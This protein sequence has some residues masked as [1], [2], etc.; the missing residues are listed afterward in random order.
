MDLTNRNITNNTYKDY[1]NGTNTSNI[2]NQN[3]KNLNNKNINI[4]LKQ[5]LPIK[6]AKDSPER[7]KEQIHLSR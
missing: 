6:D 1:N 3:N 7:N 4:K 2:R 5:S